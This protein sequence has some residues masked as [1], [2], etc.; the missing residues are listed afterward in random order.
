MYYV[1]LNAVFMQQ[2]SYKTSL[3]NLI[4]GHGRDVTWEE[5]KAWQCWSIVQ[6]GSVVCSLTINDV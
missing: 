2:F 5:I 4:C 6:F 1:N 3:R